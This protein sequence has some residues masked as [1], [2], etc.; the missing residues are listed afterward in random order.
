MFLNTEPGS[1]ILLESVD[2]T[3][4]WLLDH[5]LP[6]GTVCSARVQTAGRGQRGRAW[7]APQ[8]GAL[9]MSALLSYSI[10]QIPGDLQ[11]MPVL[12]GVAL[13]D[14]VQARLSGPDRLA[15]KWPNDLVLQ[16]HQSNGKLAGVLI[17]SITDSQK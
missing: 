5:S 9:L 17:E 13:R 4:R 8:G 16:R 14:V 15:L 12:A 3:N 7:L 6:S 10:E 11:L 2:S 1:H